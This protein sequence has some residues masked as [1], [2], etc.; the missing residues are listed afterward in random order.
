MFIGSDETVGR[1]DARGI[2]NMNLGGLLPA[3]P[4]RDSCQII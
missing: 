3:G 4:E 1:T 2:R